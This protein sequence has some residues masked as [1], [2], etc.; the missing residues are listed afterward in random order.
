MSTLGGNVQNRKLSLNANP[1]AP[2]LISEH[3]PTVRESF[4]SRQGPEPQNSISAR[5][6]LGCGAVNVIHVP[7]PGMDASLVQPSL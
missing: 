1:V 3:F 7:C 2:M 5:Q 4:Y 6:G